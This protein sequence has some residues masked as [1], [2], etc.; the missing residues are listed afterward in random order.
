MNIYTSSFVKEL[1]FECVSFIENEVRHSLSIGFLIIDKKNVIEIRKK[2]D[3]DENYPILSYGI[4]IENDEWKILQSERFDKGLKLAHELLT[5][6]DR[7]NEINVKFQTNGEI[8]ANEY[9]E[10]MIDKSSSGTQDVSD[11]E[12]NHLRGVIFALSECLHFIVNLIPNSAGEPSI[13]YEFIER[14]YTHK[15]YDTTCV[16]KPKTFEFDL[17]MKDYKFIIDNWL[18]NGILIY[19]VNV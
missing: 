10:L 9:F 15:K 19:A 14:D 4:L 16:W 8:E 13:Q 7:I 11:G 3:V 6:E 2:R 1:E 17:I 18:D 12:S 5:N